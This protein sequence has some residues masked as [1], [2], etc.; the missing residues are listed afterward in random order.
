MGYEPVVVDGSFTDAQRQANLRARKKGLPPPFVRPEVESDEFR[1]QHDRDLAWARERDLEEVRYK[2]EVRAL[3]S[4]HAIYYG[5]DIAEKEGEEEESEYKKKQKKK[6]NRPNP[7]KQALKIKAVTY[8]EKVLVGGETVELTKAI[9]P[10]CWVGCD[11]QFCGL[12]H[13]KDMEVNG[14]V[15]FRHWLDLRDKARKDLLWLC[16]LIG[17]TP[18]HSVHQYVC[19]QFVQ[20]NFDGLWKKDYSLE[21]YKQA[22]YAQKRF[23]NVGTDEDGDPIKKD[24]EFRTN[25]LMLL[26]QRGGYKSTIDGIDCV[27]WLLNAPDCRIMVITAFRQLAKK[28]AKE[29]KAYF[30]LPERA[31]PTAFHMLFP[32]YIT[33][34]VMGRSDGPLECPARINTNFFK[35]DSMWFTSMESS[36][37]GDHCCVLKGD[38]IVDPDNSADEEM[39]EALKFDFDSR[40]TDLLDPWGFVDVTGTRYF[41]DDM[42]GTRFKVNPESKRVSPFR[43]SCRG[44]WT[45]SVDD[46]ILYSLPND[47]S[48]KLTVAQIIKEKRGYLVFPAKNN[49]AKLRNIYD[50]KGERNFKNQQMNE[51]TDKSELTD[52]VNHFSHDFMIAHLRP[53]E[54]IPAHAEYFQIWDLAYSESATSDFSVGVHIALWKLEDGRVSMAITDAVFGKWKSSD[55]STQIALF[56]RSHPDARRIFIEKVNGF[57]WLYDRILAAGVL[58]GVPQLKSLVGPFDIDNTKNA[59]RNRIKNLELLM[60]DDRLNFINGALWNDVCFRQFEIFTGEPSTKSRK[61]DFPD[62]ISFAFKTILPRDIIKGM[63]EDTNKS[64]EEREEQH[65][66]EMRKVQHQRMHGYTQLPSVQNA[67]DYNPRKPQPIAE[68]VV[69]QVSPRNAAMAQLLKILPPAFRRRA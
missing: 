2:S 9:E 17:K 14:I 21:D 34:G 23:A 25:E 12:D 5:A 44:A 41:T 22:F 48:K 11:H 15:S 32:E 13:R 10:A 6:N 61:D 28:R 33:R 58:Y 27:Q 40:K 68:P 3:E 26:E 63:A 19:N 24:G 30:Y 18:F 50:E 4:L 59:K 66:A 7:S 53:K 65:K 1:T 67:S 52:F 35:E 45:L 47:D 37:T 39:R 49:W 62:V 38:D 51:A 31:Q 20:K 43:Y 64:R 29:I 69:E 46:Q 56:Y 60:S 8:T 42:Y 36:A 55:L 57:E 16:R 54:F